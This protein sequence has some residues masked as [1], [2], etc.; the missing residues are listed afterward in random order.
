MYLRE[1]Q[2]ISMPNQANG[3]YEFGGCQLDAAKRRL[4]RNGE[5]LTLA[6]KTFDLLLLLVQSE[7]RVLNKRELINSLW[8][9]TFVEEASLSFQI[10]T[11]RKALGKDGDLWIETVPKHGYRFA[12]T[13][14]KMDADPARPAESERLSIGAGAS[15]LA[16]KR[17][18]PRLTL[19]LMSGVPVLLAFVFAGL[20]FRQ[21]RQAEPNEQPVRFFVSPPDKVVLYAAPPAVSPDSR[22]LAF[23]GIDPD[24]KT[25]LW[26]R[27]LSSL[28]AELVPGTEGAVSPFWSPDSRSIGFF[29]D[30]KLK[31]SDLNG[32]PPQILCDA[33]ADVRPVGTWNRQSVILFNSFDR[34][35]LF[36]VAANGGEPRPVTL[37]DASRREIFHLWPQF[38]PDGRHFIYLVQSAPPENTG[39]YAGSLDSKEKKRLVNTSSLPAYAGLPSGRGYLLFMHAATLMAQAFDPRKLEMQGEASP[40]AEDVRLPPTPA[41]GFAAF[42]VSGPRVLAYQALGQATT[43]LVWFDRQGRRLGNVSEAGNYSVPALS[44]DEKTLAVTRIDPHVGTRDLWLFDLARS[45]PSR[46]TFDSDEE[47]NPTWSP[48]GREVAFSFRKA[49][50]DIYLKPATG[51]GNAQPLLQSSGHNI[52]ERWSPDGR[53]ILY[54]AEGKLW[55]LSLNGERKQTILFTTRGESKPDITPN[56]R[57]MVYQSSESGRTEV[58]VQSFPPAGSKWQV[59]TVGGEEPYWRRD[60]KELFYVAGKRLMAVD[61]NTDG[62]VFR[63]GSPKALFEMR[64]EMEPRRSRYQVAA[65][66]Q[67]FLVNVPLESTLSAPITVVTNWTA[68]L[69]K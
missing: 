16:P 24:G 42:S 63:W 5:N 23:V 9:D 67:R 19:L 66:G 52:I 4:S 30:G 14:T 11:L 31:R 3:L 34:R 18:R 62:Q 60:G 50:I 69:K 64:L 8:P 1:F 29:A 44:P 22:M 41:L 35:G 49:A 33:S 51:T 38:L 2:G 28:K 45:T 53:F 68:G 48:D 58:Y 10:A 13:V 57:W 27:Q 46:F 54:E 39:I 55:A 7:G 32:G 59:S 6:P 43:E 36:Q 37:V 61:V 21:L 40:V 17:Q 15:G 25:R 12:A 26:V 56:M 65:N 20:Y 47:T